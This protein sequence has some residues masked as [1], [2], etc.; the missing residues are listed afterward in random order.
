MYGD[1]ELIVGIEKDDRNFQRHPGGLFRGRGTVYGSLQRING[2]PQ[3]Q[4]AILS[5]VWRFRPRYITS[6][7]DCLFSGN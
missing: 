3:L 1:R 4:T 5:G 2:I 7:T 6:F